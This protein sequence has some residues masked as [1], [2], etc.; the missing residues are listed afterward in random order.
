[1]LGVA[2]EP[3]YFELNHC[4]IAPKAFVSS[5]ARTGANA[6]RLGMFSHQGHAYFP[7]R[8]AAPAR[9]QPVASCK[10]GRRA[11]ISPRP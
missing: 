2:I 4:D 6:I 7:S 5:V 3:T 10:D 11:A 1:M 8:S 9:A